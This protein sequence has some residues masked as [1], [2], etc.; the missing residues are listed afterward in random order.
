MRS[1]DS[2]AGRLLEI[3]VPIYLLKLNYSPKEVFVYYLIY[4]VSIFFVFFISANLSHRYGLKSSL[5]LSLPFLLLYIW[6]L[7]SLE[8]FKFPLALIALIYGAR[9][10]FFWF[11]LHILLVENSKQEE[12]G[13]N[14][15]KFHGYSRIVGIAAPFAGAF[16][17]S[18]G[19]FN[20]LFIIGA[21]VY[22]LSRFLIFWI[23]EIRISLD[24]KLREAI[25]LVRT[26]PKY[27]TAEIVEN[28]REE[29]EYIVWPIFVFL[30]FQ[31]IFSVG[32]VGSL[33]AIGSFLFIQLV[34]RYTDKS[35]KRNLLK[36]G[37]VV[38][39]FISLARFF[40]KGEILFYVLSIL[41]G[42][43]GV[44]LTIP[45]SAI[46]YGIAKKE[47]VAEFILLRESLI[48]LVRSGFYILVI[49]LV[50]NI[51]YTFLVSAISNIYF[52]FY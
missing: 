28:T 3:F 42:F 46:G 11:P 52:L 30:I 32:I 44:L 5:F 49:L 40:F 50:N 1:I 34:G 33:T 27:I 36:V 18:T 37:A 2:F 22:L 23:P 8:T 45:M 10:A 29:I 25:N 12:I 48:L 7:Y 9:M 38:A 26:Y 35:D 21:L 43:F 39:I 13:R 17:V 19:G 20:L 41:A 31:N 47:K 6:M 24:L 16:I 4:S 15:A 14:L 51:N